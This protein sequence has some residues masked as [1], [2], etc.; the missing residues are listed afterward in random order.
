MNSLDFLDTRI[1]NM[2][3]E[4]KT[5]TNGG[6][7]CYLVKTGTGYI[8]IDTGFSSGRASLEN[9]LVK[10]G[11]QPGNLKLT[12]VTPGFIPSFRRGA[13]NRIWLGQFPRRSHCV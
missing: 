8:L 2:P 5:I 3:Q 11:C 12:V 7:N 13:E 4:I 1:E 6:V 10:A 9:E